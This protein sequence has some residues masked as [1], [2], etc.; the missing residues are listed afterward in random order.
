VSWLVLEE[1]ARR[2]RMAAVRVRDGVWIGTEGRSYFVPD[3]RK[4]REAAAGGAAAMDALRAPMTGKVVAV[5]V[6]PGDDVAAGAVLVVLEAMKMEYRLTAPHAGRVLEVSCTAGELV[7]LGAA[8]VTLGEST[9]SPAGST[10][11][12]GA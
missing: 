3:P 2:R 11:S 6:E 10:A 9:E 7:D 1:G 8:L 12:A 4:R 5:H